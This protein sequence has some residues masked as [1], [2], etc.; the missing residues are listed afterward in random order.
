MLNFAFSS[1]SLTVIAHKASFPSV[2]LGY[3]LFKGGQVTRQT[4][5]RTAFF[6][7]QCYTKLLRTH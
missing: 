4:Y 5:I 1:S 2:D 6:T 7:A 3:C